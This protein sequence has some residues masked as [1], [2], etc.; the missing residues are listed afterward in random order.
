ML[1]RLAFALLTV[2]TTLPAQVGLGEAGFQLVVNNT[3]HGT[4]CPR[5]HPCTYA[6]GSLARGTTAEFVV[7]GVQFQ[8]WAVALWIDQPHQC[9]SIPGFQNQLMSAAVI[10]AL[11]GA[12]TEQDAIR[13]CPGGIGRARV[14]VPASLPLGSALTLQA[15]AWSY[16]SA[17]QV[18]TFTTA[19][20]A[21]VQ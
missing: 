18:P 11:S 2:A 1:Q 4:L 20:R 5:V 16:L 6:P 15:L 8:P 14:L 3:S 10:L 21:V 12:M 17:N 19:I 9:L 13:A 7:R